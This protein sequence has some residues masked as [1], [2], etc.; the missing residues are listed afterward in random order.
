MP[1]WKSSSYECP[2]R[3]EKTQ[4]DHFGKELA[5]DC[6]NFLTGLLLFTENEM[7]FLNRIFDKGEITSEL[8]T[9]DADRQDRI[10]R[11][12]LLEWKA[13]NVREFKK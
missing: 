13:M 11:H 12:P 7:E 5:A 2:A 1:G 3:I 9:D 10:R 8:L 4:K 6:R